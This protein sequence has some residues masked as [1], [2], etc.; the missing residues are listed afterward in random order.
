MSISLV[1]SSYRTYKEGTNTAISFIVAAAAS[2]LS[3][4]TFASCITLPEKAPKRSSKNANAKVKLAI[5]V[6]QLDR[7]VDA[8]SELTAVPH[9]PRSV[10]S[11]LERAMNIR[12]KFADFYAGQTT[13]MKDGPA[14]EEADASDARHRHFICI[15]R[16]AFGLFSKVEVSATATGAPV[17]GAKEKVEPEL[18]NI[19]DVLVNEDPQV[20]DDVSDAGVTD[21]ASGGDQT[22]K[23][24]SDGPSAKNGQ[25]KLLPSEAEYLNAWCLWEDLSNLRSYLCKQWVRYRLG[26]ITAVT[27]SAVMSFAMKVVEQLE[28]AYALQSPTDLRD[29]IYVHK[30]FTYKDWWSIM[31]FKRAMD[32]GV[33]EETALRMLTDSEKG[34]S[35][36]TFEETLF[37]VKLLMGDALWGRVNP[38]FRDEKTAKEGLDYIFSG[39]SVQLAGCRK[40][41]DTYGEYLKSYE[42]W[43]KFP[44]RPGM[45]EPLS[46]AQQYRSMFQLDRSMELTDVLKGNLAYWVF[47][48][49]PEVR[50]EYIPALDEDALLTDMRD[51]LRIGAPLMKAPIRLVFACQMLLDALGLM[52]ADLSSSV[53]KMRAMGQRIHTSI[54]NFQKLEK[55]EYGPERDTAAAI[56]EFVTKFMRT[57]FLAIL[58]ACMEKDG[59]KPEETGIKQQPYTMFYHNP[60]LTLGTLS[61]ACTYYHRY[62]MKVVSHGHHT[63]RCMH[64]YNALKKEGYLKEPLPLFEFL[65][66]YFGDRAFN[67]RIPNEDYYKAAML[68]SYG[69]AS[70]FAKD[71]NFNRNRLGPLKKKPGLKNVVKNLFLKAEDSM[72][73]EYWFGNSDPFRPKTTF[74]MEDLKRH[75]AA[76]GRSNNDDDR[77]ASFLR[78]DAGQNHIIEVVDT[79]LEIAEREQKETFIYGID[80]L[81]VHGLCHNILGRCVEAIDRRPFGKM[82]YRHD[83]SYSCNVRG[84]GGY[85]L[86]HCVEMLKRGLMWEAVCWG[87]ETGIDVYQRSCCGKA[88]LLFIVTDCQNSEIACTNVTVFPSAKWLA[89]ER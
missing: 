81:A 10:L 20:P 55:E 76:A 7:I 64:V 44:R 51:F 9:L 37:I 29:H 21:S 88:Q 1:D 62:G 85:D 66:Q 84:G 63:Q 77:F 79:F 31:L 15:L 67:G 22:R 78:N 59:F 36:Y 65:M 71:G 89:N 8:L 75:A 48:S 70:H 53:S 32:Q 60:W 38:L 4:E 86:L 2:A 35:K 61:R 42:G 46:S 12:Q 39:V 27:L 49:I 50:D 80:W 25:R 5:T 17:T 26:Q 68:A 41:F 14:K 34:D 6:T 19:Y 40:L 69:S 54:V 87:F 72:I 58:R 43:I 11:T 18:V 13:G 16:K 28:H 33:P 23:K 82:L 56:D 45:K 30:Y 24:T 83:T 47:F 73:N 3:K 52:R 57:D 74:R